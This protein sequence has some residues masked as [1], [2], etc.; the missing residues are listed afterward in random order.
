MIDVAAAR[1]LFEDSIDGTVG[2]EE[3]FALLD[4]HD[5]GLVPAFERL[6][7]AGQADDVLADAIAGELISSEIEIRSGR[8]ADFADARRRQHEARRRLF[9]LAARR[10]SRSGRP[11]RTRCRTTATST[12]STRRTTAGSRRG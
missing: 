1:D 5:L 2:I 10:A 9:A 7:D 4:P 8:G 6:R 12:S 3:E 11:A